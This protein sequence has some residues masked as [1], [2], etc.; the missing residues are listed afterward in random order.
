M[1]TLKA[2]MLT[3]FGETSNSDESLGDKNRHG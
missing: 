2:L 3:P 1:I